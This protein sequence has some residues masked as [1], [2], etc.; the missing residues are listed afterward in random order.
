MTAEVVTTIGIQELFKTL[1]SI[2]L[3]YS[4]HYGTAKIYDNVC[5]PDGI[6]GY[7]QGLITTSSPWCKMALEI[8]K[9]TENHY[10]GV[11]LVGLS[12]LLLA[13]VGI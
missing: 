5:V 6:S 3:V 8:M 13:G 1:L 7:L 12:R 2:L 9:T 4:T 10:S 11:I